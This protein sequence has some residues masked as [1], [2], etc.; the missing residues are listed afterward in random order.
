METDLTLNGFFNKDRSVFIN[1]A[2]SK[3]SGNRKG[4][5][6]STHE[7]KDEN[8]KVFTFAKVQFRDFSENIL[9]PS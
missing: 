9:L 7:I 8:G 5:V 3:S 2:V 6:I 1:C 4:K